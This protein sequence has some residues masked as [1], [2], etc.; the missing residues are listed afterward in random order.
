MPLA[1]MKVGLAGA[2]RV[3]L[4]DSA[5]PHTGGM[6]SNTT[7]AS[8]LLGLRSVPIGSLTEASARKRLVA[9]TVGIPSESRVL[10]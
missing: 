4:T 1:G 6:M 2:T 9:R 5:L 8:L 3:L 7:V 10:L